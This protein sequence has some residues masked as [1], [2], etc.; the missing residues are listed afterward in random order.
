MVLVSLAGETERE[1][2]RVCIAPFDIGHWQ[3][4]DKILARFDAGEPDDMAVSRIG[5]GWRAGLGTKR[6]FEQQKHPW[7][8]KRLRACECRLRRTNR[9]ATRSVAPG[10]ELE[11]IQRCAKRDGRHGF[12]DFAAGTKRVR[13]LERGNDGTVAGKSSQ[14]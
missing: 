1:R 6:F 11:I 10:M 5:I 8:E 7:L 14:Q 13:E 9:Q 3:S 12:E 2:Q 4:F